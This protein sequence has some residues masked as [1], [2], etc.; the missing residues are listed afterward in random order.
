MARLR[1]TNT[2]EL[3]PLTLAGEVKPEVHPWMTQKGVLPR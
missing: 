3:D 1:P 2:P